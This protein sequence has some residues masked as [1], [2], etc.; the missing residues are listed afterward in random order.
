ML[1]GFIGQFGL[2]FVINFIFQLIQAIFGL[3]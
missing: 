3:S 1:G 2:M